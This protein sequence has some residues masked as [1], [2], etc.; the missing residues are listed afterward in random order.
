MAFFQ[1]RNKNGTRRDIYETALR[2]TRVI[3]ES[4]ALF[5]LND[6]VDIAAAVRADGVHLGQD[7]LPIAVARRILGP[8]ALVGISTHNLEQAKAAQNEGVDYIGF[9]PVYPTNT[10][11]AGPVRGIVRLAAIA[12]SVSIPVIAI[13]G[14][15]KDTIGDVM[16]AGAGGAAVISA[17][18]AADN[19][20]LAVSELLGCMRNAGLRKSGGGR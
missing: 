2:L 1:Y 3:R 4:G 17:V 9:G 13:G 6:H 8:E 11:D 18:C 7:D 10:K 5:I 16:S 12:A 19:I 20:S 15:T 14:M